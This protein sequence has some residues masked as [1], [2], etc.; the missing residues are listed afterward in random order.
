MPSYAITGA[1]RGLGY[2]FVN[3]LSSEAANTVFALVRSASTATKV[4]TLAGERKNIHIVQC[5]VTKPDEVIA[6]AEKIATLSEGSLDV[7]VHNA[8]AMDMDTMGMPP[9]AFVA[10]KAEMAVSAMDKAF[11]TSLYGAL[12]ITN[13]LIPLIEKS[14]QRKIIH[15]STGM[16]DPDLIKTTG[17]SYAV[18]YVVSK[19][20]MN[21][22]VAKYAAELKD[23][24]IKVLALSPGWVDTADMTGPP[25]QEMLDA[26]Q[27]MLSQFQK[28]KPDL[29][30]PITPEESVRMQLDVI[31]DLDE[32]T[33]G[34][35]VSHH[36][37]QNWF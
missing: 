17:I 22:L 4:Q 24:G 34:T 14:Q 27:L 33:S 7:L 25:P 5:D 21:M 20:A 2:E 15:I 9:S 11:S 19:A 29:A 35:F 31:R 8:V 10:E 16:A 13:A 6:A 26:F 1:A 28:V 3:Q 36:G 37:D 30:G 23:K 18:P 12:W 32:K